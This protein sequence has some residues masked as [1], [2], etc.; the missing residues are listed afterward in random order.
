VVAVAIAAVVIAT[1]PG[2]KASIGVSGSGSQVK[3]GA[4][5]SSQVPQTGQQQA[6]V[7]EGYLRQSA[8]AR[9][10]VSDAIGSIGGC[11]NIVGAVAT[12][13][14]AADTRAHILAGL[15]GAQVTA[16]P[17]GSTMLADLQQALQASAAADRDYAAWGA[18]AATSCAGHAAHTTEYSAAQQSDAVATAAKQRFVQSWNTVAAQF[19]LSPQNASAF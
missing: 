1:R 11:R 13:R 17:G 4:S 16:L 18:A 9:S 14:N 7:I 3:A 8:A 10:G 6:A 2:E 15:T 12:L 5:T 19:G